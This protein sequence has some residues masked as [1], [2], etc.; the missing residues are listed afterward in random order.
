MPRPAPTSSSSRAPR[1]SGRSRKSA[2]V[3]PA[4]LI[5]VFDGGGARRA[6]RKPLEEIGFK[7]AIFPATGFLAAA[8]ALDHAYD[9][10]MQTGSGDTL[11]DNVY[12]FDAFTR[13]IGF[14][15]V[16]EFEQRW[17]EE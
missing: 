1:A 2:A 10:I 13:T 17:P 12:S 3:R 7:L 15:K 8:K 11:K 9:S 6:C 14:E 4:A 5:N 16:W